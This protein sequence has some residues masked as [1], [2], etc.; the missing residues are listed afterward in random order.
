MWHVASGCESNGCV[1]VA[2]V[3]DGRVA[4]RDSKDRTGPTLVLTPGQWDEFLS[5]VRAGEFDR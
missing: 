4:V 3:P 1:E 2:N 5:S